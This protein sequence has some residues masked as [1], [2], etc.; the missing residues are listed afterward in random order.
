M[1]N[2]DFTES[3]GT[4]RVT[5]GL[6]AALGVRQKWGRLLQPGDE[7]PTRDPVAVIAEDVARRFF[8]DPAVAIGETITSGNQSLRVIGVMPAAF[9]F[10]TSRE[11]IWRPFDLSQWPTNA[12][13]RGLFELAP[14]V[15]LAAAARAV[16]DRTPAV[17]KAVTRPWPAPNYVARHLSDF[18]ADT[19]ADTVFTVLMAAAGCLLLIACANVGSLELASAMVRARSFAIHSALGASRGALVRIALI[20]GAILVGGGVLLAWIVARFGVS[21]LAASLPP[22]MVQPLA[23]PIDLDPRVIGFLGATAVVAWLVSTLPV[24]R[25]ATQSNV[26]DLLKRDDRTLRL[27]DGMRV[28]H[29]LMVGQVALTVLLLVVSVLT[30]R[31]YA[32]NVALE[33]GFDSDGVAAVGVTSTARSATKM[34]ELDR[35]ILGRLRSQLGVRAI[36]RT[37]A[38]PPTAEAGIGGPLSIDG[39][40]TT[41]EHIKI[42]NYVVG[43][44]YFSTLGIRLV[45]GRVFTPADPPNCVVVDQRFAERYWPQGDVLG[46]RYHIGATSWN[47]VSQFEIIGVMAPVRMESVETPGGDEVFV[48]YQQMA[49][50]HAPLRYVVRLDDERQLGALTSLVRSLAPGAVVRVDLVEE[51]YRRLYGDVRLAATVT[52]GFGVLAFVIAMAGVYGLMA[53]LVIGRTREIG[54]RIALGARAA[55]IRRIFLFTSARLV[56]IGAALGIVGAYAASGAMASML[57]GVEATDPM[58]FAGVVCVVI[59]TAL[60]ATWLPARQAAHVDPMIS[61]R[62]E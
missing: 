34:Q 44:G 45:A 38:I 35:T 62:A 22:T 32:A 56:F 48:A 15:D 41:T 33:K 13:V 55:D 40:D 42:T 37:T 9:R 18:A 61:L 52:G 6:L 47:G 29:M 4:S 50:T 10:P 59:V 30:V 58:T 49:P 14:G 57:F 60:L 23:N 28:R 39:R 27:S 46:A 12:G 21:A 36:A 16:T 54:V 19:R 26:I 7:D 20:E 11:R 43:P 17:Q 8:G 51:R 31:T 2:G 25:K 1:T 3:I 24:C 5:P 53:F